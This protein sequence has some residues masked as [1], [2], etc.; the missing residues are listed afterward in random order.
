ML[1]K[2]FSAKYN[3]SPDTIRFYEKIGILHPKR[4][5]NGYRLFDEECERIIQLVVVLKQLDFSLD[6]IKYLL[7]L[8]KKPS[9]PECNAISS[10]MF[11]E[12]IAQLE[13]KISFLQ[14]AR[15]QLNEVKE[16]MENNQYMQNHHKIKELTISMYQQ[17]TQGGTKQG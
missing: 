5:K 7:Y 4:L 3:I 11:Q 15:L 2:E 12:K 8:E 16:L 6:E 14:M 9:S 10:N 1:I 17:L 13:S